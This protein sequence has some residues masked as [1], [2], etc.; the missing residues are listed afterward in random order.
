[1][2]VSAIAGA[3][4]FHPPQ[5]VRYISSPFG[6]CARGRSGVRFSEKPVRGDERLSAAGRM[7]RTMHGFYWLIE[8][9]LAGCPRPGSPQ[10]GQRRTG[11]VLAAHRI[12]AGSTPD[13]ALHEL[14][15]ICPGAIGSPEQEDALHVFA[16]HRDWIL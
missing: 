11:T 1:R 8:G 2:R 7:E 14:R 3:A 9:S 10:R 4:A 13:A 15:A 5:S 16:R 6:G 12:R